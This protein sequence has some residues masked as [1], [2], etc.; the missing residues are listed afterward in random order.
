MLNFRR[1]ASSPHR[2][3]GN[4]FPAR[5]SCFF[6]FRRR[7]KWADLGAARAP[8][9]LIWGIKPPK[10]LPEG[11]RPFT[12]EPGR[13]HGRCHPL[14]SVAIDLSQRPLLFTANL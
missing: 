2:H 4:E 8:N 5:Q 10:T 6:P 12:G 9:P 1:I 13:L 14:G 7:G 3:G 11:P